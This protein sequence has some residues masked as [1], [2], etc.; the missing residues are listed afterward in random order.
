MISCNITVNGACISWNDLSILNFIIPVHTHAAFE[1]ISYSSEPTIN[2]TG[3]LLL[4]SCMYGCHELYDF[5][6]MLILFL[7][8]N[9]YG[10]NLDSDATTLAVYRYMYNSMFTQ[11]LFSSN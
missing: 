6:R 9:N 1:K 5:G 7:L 2:W 11:H 3:L 8:H 4:N 10:S